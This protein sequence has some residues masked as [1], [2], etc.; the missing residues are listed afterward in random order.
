M[1]EDF[2]FK[3]QPKKVQIVF[4]KSARNCALEVNVLTVEVK[5][6]F[7]LSILYL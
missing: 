7:P 4:L 3:K 1:T 5:F 6:F 2:F